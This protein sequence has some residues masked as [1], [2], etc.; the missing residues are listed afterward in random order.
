MKAVNQS[1]I[2]EFIKLLNVCQQYV[3]KGRLQ[4]NNIPWK[5]LQRQF[6]KGSMQNLRQGYHKSYFKVIN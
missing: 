4:G 5:D 3:E 2:D 6:T 1:K